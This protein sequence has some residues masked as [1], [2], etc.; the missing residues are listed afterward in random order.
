MG[1]DGLLTEEELRGDLGVRLAIDDELRDVELPWGERRESLSLDVLA[2]PL[3]VIALTITISRDA[4]DASFPRPRDLFTFVDV[5]NGENAGGLERT[6]AAFPDTKLYDE[7][8]FVQS[9]T[10]E[11]QTILNLVFVL[12]TFSVVVSRFGMVNTL[13][14]SVF[15]RTRELGMLRAIGM[16]AGRPDG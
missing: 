4:I 9:R 16:T 14:L 7:P 10:K 1:L 11:F 6:V 8:G 5:A 12:L 13:V 3:P 2:S 15:E